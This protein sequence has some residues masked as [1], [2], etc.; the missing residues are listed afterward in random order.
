MRVSHMAPLPIFFPFLH[1]HIERGMA[2][3]R[4][5]GL[6]VFTWIDFLEQAFSAVLDAIS[7]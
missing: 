4:Q 2:L 7:R 6:V 1:L 5:Q 3:S